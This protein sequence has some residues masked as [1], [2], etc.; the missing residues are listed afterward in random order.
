M[1]GRRTFAVAAR[2]EIQVRGRLDA[3]WSHQLGGLDVVPRPNGDSL[4]VGRV[5]DQAALYGLLSRL[6]DLGLVLISVQRI[7]RDLDDT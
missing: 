2:Y 6:R 5:V 4:L 3:R 1:A 7:E